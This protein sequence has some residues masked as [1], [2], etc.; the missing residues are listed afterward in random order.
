M[1]LLGSPS[2]TV[3]NILQYLNKLNRQSTEQISYK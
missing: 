1:E 2:P 3:E